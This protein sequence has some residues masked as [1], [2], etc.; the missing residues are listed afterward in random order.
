ML[1]IGKTGGGGGGELPGWCL[2][3]IEAPLEHGAL[4]ARWINGEKDKQRICSKAKRIG[5]G[6]VTWRL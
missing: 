5:E 2:V 1:K 6:T 4:R 3:P